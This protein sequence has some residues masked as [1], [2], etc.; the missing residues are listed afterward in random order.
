MGLKTLKALNTP[1]ESTPDYMRE[2]IEENLEELN[3]KLGAPISNKDASLYDA[4]KK[5]SYLSKFEH[6]EKKEKNNNFIQ[7]Q[8]KDN[9]I[10]GNFMI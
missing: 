4:L 3:S 10:V 2:E 5:G 1:Q 9:I 6:K 8:I 7:K